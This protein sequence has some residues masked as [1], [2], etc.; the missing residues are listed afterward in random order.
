MALRFARGRFASG[1]RPS[2]CVTNGTAVS[3]S[4]TPAVAEGSVA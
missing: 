3:S 2:L 4:G 1:L